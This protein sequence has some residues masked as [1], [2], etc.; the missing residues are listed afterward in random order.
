MAE[1][2]RNGQTFVLLVEDD[3]DLLDLLQSHL[4]QQGNVVATANNGRRAL[5]LLRVIQPD[6]IVSDMMMPVLDGFGFLR[7]Y[8]RT[9][10]PRAPVLAMSTF[11]GYLEKARKLGASATLPKP[12]ELPQ[13]DALVSRLVAGHAEPPSTPHAPASGTSSLEEEHRLRTLLDLEL[14]EVAPEASLHRFIDDVARHFG[15]PMAFISIITPD[16]QFWTAACGIPEAV[17]EERGGPRSE[18]FC[19]HAVAARAAL[20]VQDAM[21]NPFFVDNPWVTDHGVR[22][23]AGVPLFGRHGEALGTLCLLDY[24]PHRFTYFDLELLGLFGRRI[25]A[26]LEWREHQ[27]MPGVPESAFRYLQ[28][29]DPEFEVFGKM[30]FGDLAVIEGCRAAEQGDSAALAIM[31]VPRRRLGE[32]IAGLRTLDPRG[33]IGRL[34]DSR[35]GWLVL[36]KTDEEAK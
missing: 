19:T 32:V 23:Y 30:A 3:P 7:A 21:D 8:M 22:F 27:A 10:G 11:A 6:V 5:D 15:V 29:L 9:E 25:M 28:Y 1:A 18:S 34:G 31:A 35:L 24:E 2:A 20:V 13:L 4:E 17:G 16:R 14:D 12:F 33:Q 26:A 36:G